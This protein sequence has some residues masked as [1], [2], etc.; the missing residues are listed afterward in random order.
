MTSYNF[1]GYNQKI[2]NEVKYDLY[3]IIFEH[4]KMQLFG[5]IYNFTAT[6]HQKIY[7]RIQFC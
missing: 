4:I 1:Y 5:N 3:R 7:I 2:Y 6:Y